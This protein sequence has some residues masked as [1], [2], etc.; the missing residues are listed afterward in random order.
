MIW[1]ESKGERE[2]EGKMR[3]NEE[4]QGENKDRGKSKKETNR[5]KNEQ[6]VPL[7]SQED[8]IGCLN[9]P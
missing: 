8:G 6:T 5:H 4:Q 7:P 9:E 3:N 1:R 2:K